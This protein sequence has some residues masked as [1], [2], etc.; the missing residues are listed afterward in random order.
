M[1]HE[2]KPDLDK[3]GIS[4]PA[5]FTVKLGYKQVSAGKEFKD[6][7]S[8]TFSVAEHAG[9]GGTKEFHVDYDFR[10]GE[11]WIH[12]LG[13]G[14][15]NLFAWFKET[16]TRRPP[17]RGQDALLLSATRSGSSPR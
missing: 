16:G 4:K 2:C 10:M 13:D 9:A 3:Y 1:T 11:A 5:K 12:R 6:I 15:V 17:Q 7:A 14:Q 8:Y